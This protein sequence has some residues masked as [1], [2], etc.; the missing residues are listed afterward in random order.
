MTRELE[1]V[2]RLLFL[3]RSL[4]GPIVGGIVVDMIG[5]NLASFGIVA[6]YLLAVSFL[7]SLNEFQSL[8][9]S[10]YFIESSLWRISCDK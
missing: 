10:L 7:S 9:K 8:T 1:T 6:A 2:Y 5:F 4:V 3:S